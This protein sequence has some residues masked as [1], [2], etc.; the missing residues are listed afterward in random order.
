[1][2]KDGRLGLMA[3]DLD[4][5]IVEHIPA[6]IA[7]EG[8]VTAPAHM[9]YDIVRKLSDGSQVDLDFDGMEGRFLLQSGRSEF[10]LA[11]LPRDDF[12]SMPD[13][14]LPHGFAVP[15]ETLKRLIDK[16]RFAIST[17]ETRYYLNGVYIHAMP[18]ER[19]LRAVATDGHRL[20]RVEADLPAGGRRHARCHCSTQ[21]NSRSPQTLG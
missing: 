7:Q 18:G 3:T 14:D 16:T 5:E 4:I 2:G 10:K 11:S 9:L 1:M 19:L 8:A 21:S 20:A 6:N 12:P 17:E 13:A 15:V